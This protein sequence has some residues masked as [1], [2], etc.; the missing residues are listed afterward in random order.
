MDQNKVWPKGWIALLSLALLAI[1]GLGLWGNQQYTAKK[2]L[3]TAMGN[4]YLR[5]FYNA[6]NHVQNAQVLLGKS[7]VATGPDQYGQLFQEIR[8]QANQALDNLAQLPV[9]D[10]VLGRTVKFTTQLGDYARTMNEQ[11]ALGKPVTQ[12]QWSTL[13]RLYEQSSS[14]NAELDKIHIAITDNKLDFRELALAGSS[15]LGREGQKLAGAGFQ[16]IDHEMRGYPTLIYDGPFS[17]H[18]EKGHAKGL[19]GPMVNKDKAREVALK[20]Y[21][22][23]H[24]QGKVLARVTGV[25]EGNIPAYRVELTPAGGA[26]TREPTIADVSQKGGHLIWYLLPRTVT[27]DGFGLDKARARAAAY[28]RERGFQD[29]QLNYHQRNHNTVTFNFVPVRQGIKIYPDLVKVTVA[30]DNGQVVGFDARGYLMSHHNR[31]LPRPQLTEKQARTLVSDKLQLQ[32]SG[33]LAL[34]PLAVE[35]EKLVWEFKGKLGSD[36]YLVYIN[37][38]DGKEENVLR[39][40]ENQDGALTM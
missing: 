7:L 3:Q 26:K 12:E 32:G 33:K 8:V 20:F 27:S 4:N 36:A 10:A 29:M 17:D 23:Q 31:D 18:L 40:I 24:Q 38:L 16:Q 37:A 9:D 28:L 39:L 34:I 22:G 15:R 2:L 25:V 21:D 14:L 13:N 30:L 35:R 19:T 1:L 6:S 5:A 11:V